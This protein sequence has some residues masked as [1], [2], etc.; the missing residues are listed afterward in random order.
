MPEELKLMP[1]S[2]RVPTPTLRDLVAVFFRKRRLWLLA[3]VGIFVAVMLYG[4][5]MPS[6]QSEMKVMVRR[7]RTEATATPTLTQAPELN[8]QSVVEEDL[9]SE[10]ELLRDKEVLAKVTASCRSSGWRANAKRPVPCFATHTSCCAS[11]P[12]ASG[13]TRWSS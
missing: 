12:I 13:S 2:A 9:N 4:V 5:L 7:N 10:V 3:F 11:R 8:R 1:R 6:Y